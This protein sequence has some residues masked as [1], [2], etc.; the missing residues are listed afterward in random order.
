MKRNRKILL[1]GGD[2]LTEHTLVSWV[3]PSISTDFPRWPE[4]LAKKLD[5]ECVNLGRSGCSNQLISTSIFEYLMK[6]P[7][8]EIGLVCCLWTN[9]TRTSLYNM[10][11]WPA[12]VVQGLF[13]GR[14]RENNDLADARRES[15][16]RKKK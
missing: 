16:R 6:N 3:D 8:K 9:Y 7:K 2:S 15:N 12:N 14:L 10:P 5:M 13:T 1:A 4:V 11:D